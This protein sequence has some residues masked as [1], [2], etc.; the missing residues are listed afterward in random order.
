MP[1]GVSWELLSAQGDAL[2]DSGALL[3]VTWE[4]LEVLGGALGTLL[5]GSEELLGAQD[6]P[7]AENIGKR[8]VFRGPGEG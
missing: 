7:S 6:G 3:G 2:V 8:I 1:W 5:G 4:L